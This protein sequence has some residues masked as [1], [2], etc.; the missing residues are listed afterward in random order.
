MQKLTDFDI[1]EYLDSQEAIMEYLS[2]VLESG[3]QDEFL[4]ALGYLVKVKGMSQI[5]K[6]TGLDVKSFDK[7]FQKGADPEF[8][9]IVHIM[10]A[11]GFTLQI[12]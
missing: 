2:Q 4:R 5:S 3:D 11:M 1:S 9:T 12:K 6:E 10:N 8:N 7:T